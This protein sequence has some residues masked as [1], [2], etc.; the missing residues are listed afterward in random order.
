MSWVS[1]EAARALFR[2]VLGDGASD[3]YDFRAEV[4]PT[5]DGVHTSFFVGKTRAVVGTVSVTLNGEELDAS[6]FTLDAPNGVI[7]LGDPPSGALLCSYNYQWFTDA[8]LDGFLE[9]AA[10]QLGFTGATDTG[11]PTTLN[12][13]VLDL[14]A[15]H[16]FTR[17]AAEYADSLQASSPDGYSIDTGRSAPNWARLASDALARAEKKY[18]W[19]LDSPLAG[20]KPSM[21]FS[22][23]QL[24]RYTPNIR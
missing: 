24:P 3:K 14:A 19:W 9:D 16:A 5:P 18:K 17:K 22:S 20:G 2:T 12:S 4:T 8:E 21:A 23:F 7:T 1:S 6:D 10:Q 15:A 13:V 11:L